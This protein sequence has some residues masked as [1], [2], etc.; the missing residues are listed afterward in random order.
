VRI[1]GT[2]QAG[3]EPVRDL[4]ERDAGSLGRGGGAYCAYVAGQPVVDLWAG[5]ARPSMPWSETTT[6]V[7]MSATKGLASL[8]VQLLVD[9]GELDLDAPVAKYWPEYA[10]AGKEGTLVRHLLLH[11]AGV[12]GFP[13]Q[14]ELLRFDGTGWDNYDAIAAGFAASTPEWEPGTRHGYHALSYGWLL[15]EL[16]RRA[17]GRSLGRFFHEEF[18]VP[19]KLEAWIGTPEAELRRVAWVY[20]ASSA[21]L[22]GVMRRAYDASIAVASDPA[23]LTGR[24]FLGTGQTNLVEQLEDVFNNPAVQRVEFPAGGG[25]ANAR[26]LARLWSVL[27]EGGALDGRRYLSDAI[28]EKFS[29]VVQSEPDLLLADVPM[30]KMLGNKQAPVPRTLGYLGNG[31]L[32]P[33][34]HRFGPNPAAYGAEGLGGQFAFSDRQSRISV[35]YVRS[36]LAVVDVLQSQL[37]AALYRCARANG[38]D[39]FTPVP[40]PR[41]KAAATGVAGNL[42]R[43]KL[44]V[45][46]IASSP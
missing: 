20:R 18:A 4:F 30:P 28:V 3:F 39:V 2:V 33:L 15:G 7:L 10:Q 27:A 41:L 13:G 34:G 19:L 9:R 8:C 42:L 26:A 22:P 40:T 44:A 43:R 21:H 37:T 29:A 24:A 36:D 23:T 46:A 25:T 5:S 17:S 1:E 45:P 12:F 11:T 38:Y 31:S 16:V 14:T 35:G 32:G 6:T